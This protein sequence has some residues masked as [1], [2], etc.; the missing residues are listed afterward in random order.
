M[1]PGGESGPYQ[2]GEGYPGSP[3]QPPANYPQSPYPYPQQPTYQQ[4]TYQQQPPPAY[5]QQPPAYQPQPIYQPQPTYPPAMGYPAPPPRKSQRSAVILVAA[6]AVVA[7]L[8]VVGVAI[9]VVVKSGKKDNPN[10][11]VAN[12]S[13]SP[14]AGASPSVATKK[15]P[16]PADGLTVGSGPVHVDIYVDYGCPPCGNFEQ[17]AGYD[18]TNYVSQNKITLGIHPVAY[19]DN[20]SKNQYSSRAAAAVAC[21]NESGKLLEYNKYLL[22]HQPEEDT[23][24][25]ENDELISDGRAIG[26]GNEFA[27]CVNSG[28]KKSW[29]VQATS[30]ANSKGVNS[31]PAAYVNGDKVNA[32]KADVVN[33]VTSAS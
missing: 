7:M 16:A 11:P 2:H 17:A 9:F 27:T 25:P 3:A 18:L 31:V 1:Y 23:A 30:A 28:A 6:V 26:L 13:S 21:A 10:P 12:G 19:I 22:E 8:A 15:N 33:A 20:R 29:V 4:P 5:Q 24:G 14:S 32:T